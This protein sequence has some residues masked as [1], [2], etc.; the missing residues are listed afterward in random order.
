[1]NDMYELLSPDPEFLSS[2]HSSSSNKPF[3]RTD[4]KKQH[5]NI[6]DLFSL[7]SSVYLLYNNKRERTR[8]P[9]LDNLKRDGMSPGKWNFE[10]FTF[11]FSITQKAELYSVQSVCKKS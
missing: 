3:A 8:A 10:V 5:S 9:V 6:S 7:L 1:M 2:T 4:K 11:T